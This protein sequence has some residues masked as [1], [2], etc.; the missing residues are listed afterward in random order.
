MSMRELLVDTVAYIPPARALESVTPADATRR[1]TGTTHS[2]AEL[3]G[4]LVFWQAWFL[5]RIAGE[6]KPM[7]TTAADGWPTVD[8]ARW[9]EVRAAFCAGLEQAAVLGDRA[10]RLDAPIVP[11]IEFPPLAAYTVREALV[12]IAA[13]NAHHLGQVITLRQILGTWPPPSGSWTW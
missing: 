2:I 8:A 7:P 4:H 6:P 13:H 5:A 9:D 1:P 12:H 11:A 3:V 10:D